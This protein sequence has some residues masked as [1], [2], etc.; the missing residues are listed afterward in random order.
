MHFTFW[1]FGLLPTIL[2]APKLN[3]CCFNKS[4]CRSS[5][6][7]KKNC[8]NSLKQNSLKYFRHFSLIVWTGDWFECNFPVRALLVRGRECRKIKRFLSRKWKNSE[9]I[10]FLCWKWYF[11][12]VYFTNAMV[13]TSQKLGE[14]PG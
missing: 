7:G 6:F 8:W 5:Y 2:P 13:F 12:K 3:V 11:E 4:I 10:N 1:K 9:P 14:P